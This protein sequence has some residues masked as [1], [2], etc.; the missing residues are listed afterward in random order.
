MESRQSIHERMKTI[1]IEAHKDLGDNY[2][3]N[4]VLRDAGVK[5]IH[6]GWYTVSYNGITLDRSTVG[7]ARRNRKGEIK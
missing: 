5:R 4:A 3:N 1:Q 2:P 6:S 7:K